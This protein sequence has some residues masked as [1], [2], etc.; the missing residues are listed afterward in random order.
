MTSDPV[1][2]VREMALRRLD[3]R[4]YGCAE[5]KAVLL[6]KGADE[7]VVDDVLGRLSRVGLIDDDAYAQALV[8]QR[9]GLR[10]QSRQAVVMD[11]RRRGLPPEVVEQATAE[12][13]DA[14]DLDGARLVAAQRMRRLAGLDRA[15]IWR[16]L[17]A[18]LA[19]KGYSPSVVATVVG[20][21]LRESHQAD[22]PPGW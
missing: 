18:A 15:V 8:E 11:M 1:E 14:A 19:R 21:A 22:A 6:R 2:M 12:L 5:L 13:D 16:R 17:S 9:H 20:E 3:R 4:A 10:H 7:S